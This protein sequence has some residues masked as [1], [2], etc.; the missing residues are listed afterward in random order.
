MEQAQMDLKWTWHLE[1]QGA[2]SRVC[3]LVQQVAECEVELLQG[4]K[5]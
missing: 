4:E 1:V 5:P 3:F 2:Y